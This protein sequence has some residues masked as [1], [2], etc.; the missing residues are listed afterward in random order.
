MINLTDYANNKYNVVPD[1]KGTAYNNELNTS[2][3]T[4]TGTEGND[5]WESAQIV[6]VWVDETGDN[7][8]LRSISLRALSADG[9]IPGAITIIAQPTADF[10][11]P[12]EVTVHVKDVWDYV[13]AQPLSMTLNKAE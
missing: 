10:T 11:E 4:A 6:N 2:D 13:V 9:K 1:A 12:T 3:G 7:D 5:I 8:Y